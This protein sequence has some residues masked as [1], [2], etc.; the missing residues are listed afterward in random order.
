M[1]NRSVR[2]GQCPEKTL[3]VWAEGIAAVAALVLL[4]LMRVGSNVATGETAGATGEDVTG[5][6]S[7]WRIGC[8]GSQGRCRLGRGRAEGAEELVAEGVHALDRSVGAWQ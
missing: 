1:V 4:V 7:P 2:P 8:S 5:L 3:S 6:R